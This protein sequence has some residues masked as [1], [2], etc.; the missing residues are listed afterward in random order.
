MTAPVLSLGD[1]LEY[2]LGQLGKDGRKRRDNSSYYEAEKRPDAIGLAVPPQMKKLLGKIGWPRMYVDSLEER[3]DIEGFRMGSK[4]EADDLLWQWWQSNR[5]DVA[6]GLAHT[7]ALIHGRAYITVA[8]PDTSDPLSDPTTPVIRVE[9]PE[10]MYAQIDPRTE[11]VT[12]AVRIYR[13]DTNPEQDRAT[14]YL[15]NSTHFFARGRFGWAEERPPVK[16]N[17]GVVPVIPL[18][19][20]K[21]MGEKNG[22]SEIFP[23]LRSQT[24]AAAR[25]MMN[26]NATAELMAVPQRVI[27]GIERDELIKNTSTGAMWDAYIANILAFGDS[28]GKI[29]QLAAAELRNFGDGMSE[30]SKLVAGITGLPPQYLA[31]SQDNPASADAIRASEDRLIKKSERKCRIFGEAWEQAMRVA[32]LVMGKGLSPEAHR[33]ETV[34]RNPATPTFNAMA[35]AV[36]KLATVATPEGVAVLPVEFARRKLEFS[37]TE[38]EQMQ[39]MD[40]D[41]ARNQLAQLLKAPANPPSFSDNPSQRE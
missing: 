28:E 31:F 40:K 21:R 13:D 24:D 16:H 37:E 33:M 5:M 17:L 14:L 10:H 6:S 20:K 26:M 36:M 25:L 30:I 39:A 3:L 38:R 11:R 22:R 2:M 27:F 32:L 34:W 18:L 15:P 8:A 4:G 12:R 29:T 7:E 1:Q 41:I 9:S 35:D 19:N 23:E